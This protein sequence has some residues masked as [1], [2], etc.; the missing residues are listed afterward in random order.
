MTATR[1]ST[2]SGHPVSMNSLQ[3]FIAGYSAYNVEMAFPI[4][5]IFDCWFVILQST[6]AA[7]VAQASSNSDP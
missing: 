6:S 4:V 1:Q 5:S 3:H 2:Y 7:T